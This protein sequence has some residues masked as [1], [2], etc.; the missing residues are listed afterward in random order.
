VAS[1]GSGLKYVQDSQTDLFR[2]YLPDGSF[3]DFSDSLDGRGWGNSFANVRYANKL[4]DAN[5]NFAT[6]T[7]GDPE[8]TVN[9]YG[10]WTDQLGRVFPVMV[11]SEPIVPDD[12]KTDEF[13]MP[14]LPSG[15]TYK[16][17][18]TRL[19]NAFGGSYQLHYIGSYK[20]GST[21]SPALFNSGTSISSNCTYYN[22]LL[23]VNAR[24][25]LGEEMFGVFNPFV[26]AEIELPNGAAYQFKYNKFGEIEKIIY[27]TG[28]R[29]EFDYAQV[30]SL[31]GMPYGYQQTNRGVVERR[32][33]ENDSSATPAVSEYSAYAG[34]SDGVY[35]TTLTAPDGTVTQNFMY[36]GHKPQCDITEEY[37]YWYGGLKW[38]YDSALAGRT[39]E[40]RTYSSDTTPKILTC[41]R[42]KWDATD[43]GIQI[44]AT[45]PQATNL[46]RNAR[47]LTSETITYDGNP[48]LSTLTGFEYDTD[49]DSAGSPL[50]VIA[51]KEYSYTAV[52]DGNSLPPYPTPVTTDPT[53]GQTAARVTSTTYETGSSYANRNILNLPTQIL[54]TD[55]ATTPNVKAKTQIFYDGLSL[56]TDGPGQTIPG[57]A[58]PGTTV[59]GLATKTRSFHDPANGSAYIETETQYNRVGSPRKMWDGNDNLSQIEYDD[60]FTDSINRNTFAFATK[61][62][63]PVPGGNGSSQSL[64]S[65]VRYEY[66]TGLQKFVTDPNGLVT[67]FEHDDPLLR[68]T[69]VTPTNSSGTPVG[70]ATVT[71]YGQAD[72]NGQIIPSQ[73]FIKVKTEITEGNWK[74]AY[75]W[76]DGLGRG[77]ISQSVDGTNGDVFVE[78]EYDNFG[79]V[80]RTSNPYR[81][82]ETVFWTE[83]TYDTAGRLWKVTAPGSDPVITT[84]SVATGTTKG[85]VV[86]VT[87]Q[88]GKLR[89]SVTNAQGQLARVDEPNSSNQ[90]GDIGSPNQPTYYEYDLLNNLTKVKQG[91]TFS[92][93]EQTRTFVY[94]ALSRLK[95]AANP[96]S[97][98]INYGYDLNG[99]LTSK[100]D[101]RGITTSYTYDALN[102]VNQRSYAGE[103]G[104]TTPTVNYS[105][106][107]TG[108]S[109]SKGKLTKVTNGTGTNRSTTE[110][111]AFD[112]V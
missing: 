26:L 57:W 60:A 81:S 65:S 37:S 85:T 43:T 22:H 56:L 87:D 48:G 106:D 98:T 62:I 15:A 82:G 71:E 51:K 52:S 1:D 35:R 78:T 29:E 76:F 61:T 38:G 72:S 55:G 3:Y 14:G 92:Q 19:A 89:R 88:A 27:P 97:G 13:V 58:D 66:E 42:T 90:L 103:S 28:G 74:E 39:F 107:A 11:P 33:Y 6:F 75:S 23:Y 59:R 70:S 93:P 49:K 34:I 102:R 36:R 47:V 20:P 9:P 63:S 64:E 2:L 10:W 67:K 54:I 68:P 45:Y 21:L 91:G 53:S 46:H 109:Y 112:I 96:E 79:R 104:Y 80:W 110:Y 50:N 69:R 73:R 41:T 84:Y 99:N 100:A 12:T 105:Y 24:N 17:T 4:T 44:M 25:W 95:S 94:D 30:D 32:V 111:T 86:T 83:N 31:A 16:L 77:T 40:T 8:A 7:A 101:A 108:V 5:G 18:W